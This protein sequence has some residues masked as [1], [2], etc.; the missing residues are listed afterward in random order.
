MAL[1]KLLGKIRKQ[2]EDLTAKTKPLL[3]PVVEPVHQP[4]DSQSNDSIMWSPRSP[5]KSTNPAKE[6]SEQEEMHTSGSSSFFSQQSSQVRVETSAERPMNVKEK[7][8]MRGIMMSSHNVSSLHDMESNRFHGRLQPQRARIELPGADDELD[9]SLVN[10][11]NTATYSVDLSHASRDPMVAGPR[12]LF[13]KNDM[14]LA[15]EFKQKQ[16]Q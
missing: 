8:I 6:E 3:E 13:N 1:N 4:D 9:S 15:I 11:Q 12:E 7:K 16:L 5:V 2:R 10:N 14:K